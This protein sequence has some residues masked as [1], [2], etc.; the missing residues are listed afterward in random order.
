MYLLWALLADEQL[1]YLGVTWYPNREWAVLLPAYSI[2]LVLLTYFVY[3]SLAL[4]RTPVFSD[5]RTFVDTKA[6]FPATDAANPYPRYSDPDAIP[7]PYDIP[8]G[9]VNRVLYGPK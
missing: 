5:I 1:H 8:I 4:A 7:E 3:F 9:V 6:H 2:T